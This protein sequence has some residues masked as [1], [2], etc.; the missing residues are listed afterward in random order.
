MYGIVET[1]GVLPMRKLLILSVILISSRLNSL[2][3]P[4]VMVDSVQEQVR[5]HTTI[6]K[7]DGIGILKFKYKW[8]KRP[9]A[10]IF[11]VSQTEIKYFCIGVDNK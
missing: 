1:A 11:D 2:E 8:R 6:L 7:D 10:C 3:P 5:K 4:H 9:P